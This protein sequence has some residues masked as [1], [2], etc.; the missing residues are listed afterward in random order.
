M[1]K[2]NIVR[3]GKFRGWYEYHELP[4][5]RGQY[6]TI[7][8]GTTVDSRTNPSDKGPRAAGRTY[9][10]KVDHV[11]PGR[12]ICIGHYWPEKDHLGLHRMEGKYLEP[13]RHAYGI[14][15]LEDLIF[16]CQ[17]REYKATTG[18]TYYGL[19]VPIE[20]PKVCWAGSG[21]YWME[22]DI[23]DVVPA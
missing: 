20:N 21:G 23:N 8:K 13:F 17:I 18:A 1:D 16:Y 7:K 3:E 10:V 11:L 2:M 14:E 22:A 19:F 9:E 5:K 6:V 12:A 15:K 4:V